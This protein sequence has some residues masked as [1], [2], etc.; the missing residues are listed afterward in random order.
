M[1]S[2]VIFI[3]TSRAVIMEITNEQNN[4]YY[5]ISIDGN[6]NLVSAQPTSNYSKNSNHA[7]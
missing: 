3:V 6:H 2:S 5:I 7:L 1:L 4:K